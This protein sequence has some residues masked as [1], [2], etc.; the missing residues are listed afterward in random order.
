MLHV[1][2]LTLLGI[3]LEIIW[4]GFTIAGNEE[5]YRLA[6]VIGGVLFLVWGLA[7][8]PSQFKVFM[9]AIALLAVFPVCIPCLKE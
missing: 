3:G 7:L 5:V 9:E 4:Q 6:A 1:T 2:Y 8:T